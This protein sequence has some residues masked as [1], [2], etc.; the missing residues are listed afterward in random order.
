MVR[1]ADVDVPGAVGE[2]GVGRAI[3][4]VHR[5]VERPLRRV[6]FGILEGRR[7]RARHQDDER[8]IVPEAIERQIRDLGGPEL[9]VDVRLVRLQQLGSRLD[10]DGLAHRANLKRQIDAADLSNPDR[11]GGLH[12]LAESLQGHLDDI[13]AGLNV[14]ER[15]GALRVGDGFSRE[16]GLGV[17][18]RDAG[19]GDD[20]ALAID[21]RPDESTVEQLRRGWR[22]AEKSEGEAD[23]QNAET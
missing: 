22:G 21:H 19:P 20:R 4:A 1:Q 11:Y 5:H 18:D 10:R 3:L 9:R 14:G 23:T 7:Q 13:R 17:D 2:R 16:I 6:G 12:R 15:V 8:L